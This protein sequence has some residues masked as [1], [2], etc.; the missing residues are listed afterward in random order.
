MDGC[1]S[2]D[3]GSGCCTHTDNNLNPWWQVDLGRL[4]L[5][6]EIIIH[7]RWDC[8]FE[9]LGPVNELVKRSTR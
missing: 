3:W 5:L 6:K 8:K 1:A 2:S 7:R 4:A 9:Y